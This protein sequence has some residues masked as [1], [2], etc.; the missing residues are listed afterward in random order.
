M[1]ELL[2]LAIEFDVKGSWG[3]I[4]P[5]NLG[6]VNKENPDEVTSDQPN[7]HRYYTF[8]SNSELEVE[9][10]SCTD[11]R[12]HHTSTPGSLI[13]QNKNFH[14]SLLSPVVFATKDNRNSQT[15]YFRSTFYITPDSSERSSLPNLQ[16]SFVKPITMTKVTGQTVLQLEILK[17]SSLSSVL[18]MY[19]R[20]NFLIR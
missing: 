5:E 7:N 17:R 10:I 16:V 8:P 11:L 1:T 14:F 19:N 18:I 9:A 3:E 12:C 6:N 2:K 15:F 20:Q 4:L 13:L